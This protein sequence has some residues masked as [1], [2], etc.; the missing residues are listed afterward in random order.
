MYSTAFL[1]SASEQLL[2]VPRGGMTPLLPVKP[3]VAWL[4]NTS[5]PCLM[6][7]AQAALSPNLGAPAAPVLWHA[8][9]VLLKISSPERAAAAG[10]LAAAGA[11]VGIIG[12]PVLS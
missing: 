7:G 10:A 9:Q 8:V 5:V 6:R 4:T 2:Q 1:I 12:A 3:W 11:A